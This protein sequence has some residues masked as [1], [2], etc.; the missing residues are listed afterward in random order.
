MCAGPWQSGRRGVGRCVDSRS[1]QHAMNAAQVGERNDHS[2]TPPQ[3]VAR[4]KYQNFLGTNR[5]GYSSPG[6]IAVWPQWRTH[7]VHRDSP[8]QTKHAASERTGCLGRESRSDSA[9]KT[10][11]VPTNRAAERIQFSLGLSERRIS[12]KRSFTGD[13]VRRGRLGDARRCAMSAPHPCAA[14]EV[15]CWSLGL[16]MNAGSFGELTEPFTSFDCG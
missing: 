14:M 4:N 11:L 3:H 2:A 6:L 8:E 12:R 15:R 5:D 7:I 16:N 1:A 13:A 10:D 9:G